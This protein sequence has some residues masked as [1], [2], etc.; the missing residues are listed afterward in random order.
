AVDQ[1]IEPGEFAR[2]AGD[3]R[4]EV[5]D[6]AKVMLEQLTAS[7]T[8]PDIRRGRQRFRL[9]TVVVQGNIVACHR[10][11]YG[12]SPAEPDSSS[13]NQRGLPPRHCRHDVAARMCPPQPILTGREPTWHP[14]NSISTASP[15]RSVE[16][17]QSK[18]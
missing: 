18:P 14:S 8:S 13:G 7:A 5:V 11:G 3:H 6:L 10:K 16:M 12:Y 15:E 1:N 9:R 4:V 2:D 17:R